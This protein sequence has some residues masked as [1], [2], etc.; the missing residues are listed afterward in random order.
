M[1]VYVTWRASGHDKHFSTDSVSL[2]F[3]RSLLQISFRI[4]RSLLTYIC[5]LDVASKQS[6]QTHINSQWV[7]CVQ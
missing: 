1:D 4:Y 6:Q 5:I 3:N 7:S 2:V